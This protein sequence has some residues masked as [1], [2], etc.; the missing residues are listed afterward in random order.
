MRHVQK[1]KKQELVKIEE[2]KSNQKDSHFIQ[3]LALLERDFQMA[4]VIFCL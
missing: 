4:F 1:K 3:I 2:K